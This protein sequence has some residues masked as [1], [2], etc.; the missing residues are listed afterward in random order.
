MNQEV[1][2]GILW[3]EQCSVYVYAFAQ[4][5]HFGVECEDMNAN[6]LCPWKKK[7]CDILC[8]KIHSHYPCELFCI[9]LLKWFRTKTKFFLR[10]CN[11]SDLKCMRKTQVLLEKSSTTIRMY[12]K[13]SRVECLD[14]THMSICKR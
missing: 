4:L 10:I 6:E 7:M 9:D 13:Q 8:L 1:K 3:R 14:G 2:L 11:A 5:N 12:L